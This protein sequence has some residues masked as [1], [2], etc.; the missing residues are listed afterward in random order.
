MAASLLIV[1]GGASQFE[2][3]EGED[4]SKWGPL[5]RVDES[6]LILAYFVLFLDPLCFAID[7]VLMR[8]ISVLKHSMTIATYLNFTIIPIVIPLAMLFGENVTIY[9]EF[10]VEDCF[11][12]IASSALLVVAQRL[13]YFASAF[14][15]APALQPLS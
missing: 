4:I 5:E 15:P 3:E 10:S 13:F 8:N 2:N 1:F 11:C 6:N 9:R 14:L 12:L 7:Q